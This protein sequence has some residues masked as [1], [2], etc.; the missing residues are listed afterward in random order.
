MPF[1]VLLFDGE[2]NPEGELSKESKTLDACTRS[3]EL[4]AEHSLTITTVR[5]LEVGTRALTHH[6]DGRW[7]EWVVDEPGEVHDTGEHAVGTYHLCWSLQYDLQVVFGSIKELGMVTPATAKQALTAALDGTRRWTVGT[8]DVT[9]T[10]SSV[11]MNNNESAWARITTIVRRWGGEVDSEISVNNFGVVSRK[12]A[13]KKHLGST[14]ANRRFEWGYNLT[15]IRRDPD[16]GPYYCQIIPQGN[17]ETEEAA[18]GYTT[19]QVA[20]EIDKR[21]YYF[22]S[23]KNIRHDANSRFLRDLEAESLFRVS[24]GKGGYEYPHT[25]IS[26]STDDD[27]ELFEL[28]KED[29]LSHTRPGV[30]YSGSVANFSKAGMDTDE[31]C[32]G[33]EV[34]VI[35]LGFNPDIPLRIQERVLKMDID[36]MG[37]DDAKLSI[38]RLTPT[39]ERSLATITRTIGP[40]DISYNTP[41]WDSTKYP[42]TTPTLKVYEIERP[43]SGS[44][45]YTV[46]SYNLEIPDYSSAISNLIDR[47]GAIESGY[48]A[49]TGSAIDYGGG[50]GGGSA[51]GKDGIIH[52]FNGVTMSTGTINFTTAAGGGGSD[53]S[54][55]S[56]QEVQPTP[57]EV[58]EQAAKWG[59]ALAGAAIA[60]FASGAAAAIWGAGGAL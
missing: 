1:R 9:T 46:P 14:E 51:V 34:Q 10:A 17:G 58:A 23:S 36:E 15:S 2:G 22:D 53:S 38:G 27:E 49:S 21:P 52:Q 44:V 35:D 55:G 8:C 41:S 32:L 20:L 45:S 47:V 24:D 60:P 33:D 7:R 48:V 16:P 11:V 54:S 31:I 39:L 19:Y 6:A 59:T 29:I 50:G 42:V 57:E 40:V 56:E 37:I 12:V 5:H 43:S 13:L 4:N 28:A 26:Y 18:D 25:V 30:S 3:E